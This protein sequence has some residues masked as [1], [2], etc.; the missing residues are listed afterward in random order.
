MQ[1]IFQTFLIFTCW[2][3]HVHQDLHPGLKMHPRCWG[4]FSK[5]N[6]IVRGE[7]VLLGGPSRRPTVR[8][9]DT[10][11]AVAHATSWLLPLQR[12]RH[13]LANVDHCKAPK[14]NVRSGGRGWKEREREFCLSFTRRCGTKKKMC[15]ACEMLSSRIHVPRESTQTKLSPP[16][17][18]A[19]PASVADGPRGCSRRESPHL[20][21]VVGKR[22]G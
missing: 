2:I 18:L 8:G 22:A 6:L 3:E 5:G 16:S 10:D 17:S 9:D 14:I 7:G 11:E 13:A 20:V 1:P 15:S 21:V 12:V 19:P 4:L